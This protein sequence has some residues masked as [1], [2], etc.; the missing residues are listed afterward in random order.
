VLPVEVL[1]S[2]DTPEQAEGRAAAD[3]DTNTVWTGRAGSAGW[4][5]ALA[6]AEMLELRAVEVDVAAGSATNIAIL[7]SADAEQWSELKD[8]LTNGPV[9]LQYLW[10]IIKN[11]GAG[12]A[13]RIRDIR[14]EAVPVGA[15]AALIR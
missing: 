7:G 2:D 12:A 9:R 6:Y 15:G 10:V 4:W 5:V 14:L 1:T 3:G 8:A 13:P 11:D